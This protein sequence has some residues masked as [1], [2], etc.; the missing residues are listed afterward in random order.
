MKLRN[1]KDLTF[2]YDHQGFTIYY[3]SLPIGGK[4]NEG[5]K[6]ARHLYAKNK[7]L[8]EQQVKWLCN[9]F[10]DAKLIQNIKRIEGEI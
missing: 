6:S 5:S 3:K 2:T 7:Y 8:A 4:R 1:E 10:G 9:G